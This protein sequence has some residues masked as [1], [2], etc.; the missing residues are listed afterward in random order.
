[1]QFQINSF[2]KFS[3]RHFFY[4]FHYILNDFVLLTINLTIDILLVKEIK[5]DLKLKLETKKKTSTNENRLNDFLKEKSKIEHKSTLMI[6]FSFIIYLICR[7]PELVNI[8]FVYFI[9]SYNLLTLHNYCSDLRLCYL[10]SNTIEFFYTLSYM[11]NIFIYYNFNK[12]FR[13]GFKTFFHF[14]NNKK[15]N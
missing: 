12:N 11:F 7:L 15:K 2:Y 4:F 14:K 3:A 13:N 8:F 5:K 9:H 10:L 1:M 6:I